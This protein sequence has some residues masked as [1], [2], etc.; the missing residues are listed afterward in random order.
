LSGLYFGDCLDVMREDIP[1]QS[2]DL[3][4]LDP[5]FN[6]KRLYNAFI[7]GA[8]WVAFKDTWQWYEAVDDFH[9][10]ARQVGLAHT[11]EGLR[12]I[13]GEGP[14]LAYLSYM[15]NRLLECY[16]VLRKGGSIYLH[17]DPTMSYYLRIVMDGIFGKS[18]FRDQIVWRR[19]ESGAK[20]SQYAPRRWG[21]NADILFYYTKRGGTHFE[22]RS[23]AHLDQAELQRLFPKVDKHGER[24]NT[25]TTAWR[26]P[27]MGERPNL[28]YPFMG[29]T[30]PLSIGLA[31]QRSADA[32]GIRQGEHHP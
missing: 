17:C 27:S 24:Y 10:V 6:S 22:P 14:D 15:A 8:Q 18:N 29:V 13:L 4:Y 3:I 19:N 9:Q 5:P 7:G 2:V 31:A 30:P 16:R 20:G 32:R 12:T 26:S 1:D 11:M 28:C 25:K 23:K 21:S